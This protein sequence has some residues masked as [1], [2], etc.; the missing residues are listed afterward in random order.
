MQTLRNHPDLGG[1]EWN[2]AILNHAFAVLSDEKRR[3]S[4]DAQLFAEMPHTEAGRQTPAQRSGEYM[5]SGPL[6]EE[7]DT[8]SRTA[9]QA[10]HQPR[11]SSPGQRIGYRSDPV[12]AISCAFCGSVF[13]GTLD[14]EIDCATCMSPLGRHRPLSLES[15]T[16]RSV[17]R[18]P[19]A[20]P[21]TFHTAWPGP[22]WRAVLH[23][24]S[25]NGFQF[26]AGNDLVPGQ[27]VRVAC[28]VFTA[29]AE[30]TNRIKSSGGQ[31]RYG[32]KFLTLRY[33]RANGAH[34]S[35]SV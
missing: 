26:T 19:S 6:N 33:S 35:A 23:D 9:D 4:Y 22:S 25:P 1:D 16:Q 14:D 7:F 13:R 29:V 30:I 24:L 34:F 3:R 11:D 8:S 27:R 18:V 5:N 31:L 10:A 17:H 28:S 2:A 20:A 12:D 32:A 21:I 15:S